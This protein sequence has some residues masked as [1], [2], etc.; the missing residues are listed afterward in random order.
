MLKSSTSNCTYICKQLVANPLI[1]LDIDRQQ[2]PDSTSSLKSLVHT[3]I[4]GLMEVISKRESQ[5]KGNSFQSVIR[6]LLKT[7]TS[8]EQQ[9]HVNQTL[10]KTIL[11]KRLI[12]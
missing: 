12:K 6:K 3:V 2:Q 10:E 9:Y 1:H 7:D 5:I 4:Q 8:F 11:L